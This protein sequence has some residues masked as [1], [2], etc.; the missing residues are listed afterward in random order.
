MRTYYVFENKAIFQPPP[1][2][3]VYLPVK[4][5]PH[6]VLETENEKE[7]RDFVERN[8]N[9]ELY[10]RTDKEVVPLVDGAYYLK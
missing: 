6:L 7:A 3:G 10:I 2:P 1:S 5:C 4:T 9:R 8:K